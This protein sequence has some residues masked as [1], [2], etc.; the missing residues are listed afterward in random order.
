M[1]IKTYEKFNEEINLRKALVGG[2][3][4]ASTL[5][6]S[7]VAANQPTNPPITKDTLAGKVDKSKAQDIINFVKTIEND[8][9]ELFIDFPLTEKTQ[10]SFGQYERITYLKARADQFS[11]STGVNLNLD[12]ITNE[13]NLFPFNINYFVVRGIDNLESP[14]LINILRLDYTAALKVAGHEVMFN[15]TRVQDVNTYGVRVNF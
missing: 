13:P 2:A 15:F 5:I 10:L 7:Y 3:I 6:P 12:L 11:E 4:G 1:R 9:P 8:T 14:T